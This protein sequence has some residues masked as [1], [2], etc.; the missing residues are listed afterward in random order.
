MER[1]T[2][3]ERAC[4]AGAD[5]V[6]VPD[7]GILGESDAASILTRVGNS[8]V[9]VSYPE[10]DTTTA[11]SVLKSVSAAD[12]TS[13]LQTVVYTIDERSSDVWMIENFDP[14]VK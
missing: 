2:Q 11:L 4:R 14:E 7:M 1:S 9:R 8:I 5:C 10:G 12:F 6:F 13:D 3:I